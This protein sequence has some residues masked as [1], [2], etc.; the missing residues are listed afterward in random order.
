M[1]SYLYLFL[2]IRICLFSFI[3]FFWKASKEISKNKIAIYISAEP[4][5]TG[6]LTGW[7]TEMSREARRPEHRSGYL[8]RKQPP[9]NTFAEMNIER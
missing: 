3:S 7:E 6:V 8:Q 5:P 1:Y 9:L 2:Y 4:P